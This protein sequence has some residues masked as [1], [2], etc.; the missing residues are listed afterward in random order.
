VSLCNGTCGFPQ[1]LEVRTQG[2]PQLCSTC[3]IT[4]AT[5][6]PDSQNKTNLQ[7]Q[8]RVLVAPGQCQEL[9]GQGSWVV[10]RGFPQLGNHW[11]GASVFPVY[12]HHWEDGVREVLTKCWGERNMTDGRAWKEM[13]PHFKMAEWDCS[14]F[15]LY[16][17]LAP[18]W[19]ANAVEITYFSDGRSG[20]QPG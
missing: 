1:G 14:V 12:P 8:K 13:P 15:P 6:D 3:E 17:S 2:Q 4:Q 10:S 16:K 9:R 20:E 7:R 11:Q 18:F 19:G 5:W